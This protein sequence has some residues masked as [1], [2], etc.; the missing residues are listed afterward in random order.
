[1][2]HASARRDAGWRLAAG[3]IRRF[4]PAG[5]AP[6]AIAVCSLAAIGVAGLIVMATSLVIVATG[7]RGAPFNASL[8]HAL[9]A[10]SGELALL[11]LTVPVVL[12]VAATERYFLS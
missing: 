11:A 1:M 2:R 10:C 8:A 6:A 4:W 5:M 7:H 9:E 12:G 3:P